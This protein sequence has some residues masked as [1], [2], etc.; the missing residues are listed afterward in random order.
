MCGEWNGI[1]QL[2]GFWKINLGEEE[3]WKTESKMVG[4][5]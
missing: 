3:R 2:K 1:E 4:W 5:S